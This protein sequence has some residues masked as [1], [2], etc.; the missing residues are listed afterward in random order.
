MTSTSAYK[1]L[2][3][4]MRKHFT[5]IS[6]NNEYTLGEY[7]SMKADKKAGEATSNLPAVR[8]TVVDTHSMTA[9][10]SYV[11]EK[12][13]VKKAPA[14][15]KTMRAFPFRTSMAAAL[16][17]V[18]ACALIFSY[19]IFTINGTGNVPSTVNA[20]EDISETEIYETSEIEKN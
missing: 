12:L 3:N 17:A 9:I 4:N 20:G 7:M 18:V 16:S 6:E 8:S 1:S 2:Y 11:N 19:G 15:D 5:V 13:T 10:F 14:K